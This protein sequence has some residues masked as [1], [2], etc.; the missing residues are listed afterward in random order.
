MTDRLLSAVG[1][2]GVLASPGAGLADFEPVELRPDEAEAWTRHVI[3]LPKA[4]CASPA[5][6]GP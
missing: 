3:P 2:L 5:E 4:R 1:V 6:H